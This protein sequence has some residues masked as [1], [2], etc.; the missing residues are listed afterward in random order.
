MA[1]HLKLGLC[2]VSSEIIAVHTHKNECF[3]VTFLSSFEDRDQKHVNCLPIA[4]Q[5]S[6]QFGHLNLEFGVIFDLLLID[7]VWNGYAD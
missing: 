4:P 6:D 7:S 3:Q 1:Y 5:Y 2:L